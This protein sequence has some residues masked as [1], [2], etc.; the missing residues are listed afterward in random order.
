MYD[1][2]CTSLMNFLQECQPRS[3]ELREACLLKHFWE[4][5]PTAR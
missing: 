4:Q 5:F 2:V 1:F 3:S